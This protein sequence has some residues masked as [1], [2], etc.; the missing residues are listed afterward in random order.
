MIVKILITNICIKSE[1][2]K[3]L[4]SDY[5]LVLGYKTLLDFSNFRKYYFC[6][7]KC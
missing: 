1:N 7:T 5:H 6:Q 4:Q 3:N 2:K